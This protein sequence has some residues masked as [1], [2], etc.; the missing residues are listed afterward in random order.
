MT[1]CA[2]RQALATPRV[3][4]SPPALRPL[5][6]Q[7]ARG[8]RKGHASQGLR[9]LRPGLWGPSPQLAQGPQGGDAAPGGSLG[10]SRELTWSP[11]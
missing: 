8:P 6:V 9:G 5:C 2:G 7:G 3:P 1:P 4:R 11:C 10:L